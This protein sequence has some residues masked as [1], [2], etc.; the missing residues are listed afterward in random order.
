MIRDA[1]A[2][3]KIACQY[4]ADL[5]SARLLLLPESLLLYTAEAHGY[6]AGAR[7]MLSRHGRIARPPM[8][9]KY[10]RHCEAFNARRIASQ[11][12]GDIF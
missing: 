7:N 8:V 10:L 11:S 9:M 2:H 1:A 3:I 4:W 5:S 12:L 6:M